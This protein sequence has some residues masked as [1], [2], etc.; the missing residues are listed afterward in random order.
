MFIIVWFSWI[1]VVPLS[2]NSC[3]R[4][5]EHAWW[6]ARARVC[7]WVCVW[8][9]RSC[10]RALPPFFSACVFPHLVFFLFSFL[11]SFVCACTGTQ[12]T[13]MWGNLG[14]ASEAKREVPVPSLLP[15]QVGVVSVA[16]VAPV[17]EGTYTSHWRLAH[18]GCQFGPRVWCSIVVEQGGGRTA[19][20]LP[21]NR[22]A[23][24]Q[25]GDT[26]RAS[27]VDTCI[28]Y[29]TYFLHFKKGFVFQACALAV[30]NNQILEQRHTWYHETF[31]FFFRMNYSMCCLDTV[32]EGT[33]LEM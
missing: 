32:L 30:R 13:F 9:A 8:V 28:H 5:N 19:L 7:G 15:G 10:L 12:L 26:P 31:F 11:Y 25:T 14:L 24:V 4:L 21:S 23:S 2:F 6:C 27:A 22:L 1:R 17:M 33:L 29:V 20:G 3:R 16:F 18:C